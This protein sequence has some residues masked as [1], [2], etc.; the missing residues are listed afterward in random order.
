MNATR[1][2]LPL[3][4][5]LAYPV[6]QAQ[7]LNST[8]DLRLSDATT[9][10]DP[11]AP[12]GDR[13]SAAARLG[14]TGDA[15]VLPFLRAG[16][17]DPLGA[18][19]TA[20]VTALAGVVDPA[21]ARLAA[22]V[23]ADPSRDDDARAAAVATLAALR[24]P[25]AGEILYDAASDRSLP[26]DLRSLAGA[27]VAQSYPELVAARGAPHRVSSLPGAAAGV[28]G[29]GLAGG[30]L[31]SSVG[32]W[33]QSDAGTVIGG[34]GGG[35]IGVGSGA[36]YAVTRPVTAGQGTAY[37]SAVGW[38]LTAGVMG[39]RAIYG[40]RGGS[41]WESDLRTQRENVGAGLRALGV[42]AGT[43]TGAL[44][45]RRDPSAEDVL[46]ADLAGYL[47]A[48]VGLA[49]VDL[50]S[51]GA[52]Y[53]CLYRGDGSIDCAA[54]SRWRQGRNAA[55]L[56]GLGAGLGLGAA[57]RQGWDPDLADL[58]FSAAVATETAVVARLLPD[59]LRAREPKGTVRLALHGGAALAQVAA[60]RWEV[61][62]GHT[63]SMVWGGALGTALGAGIPMLM[64]VDDFAPVAGGMILG[65]VAGTAG[66]LLA[67]PALDLSGG[68]LAMLGVGVSFMAAESAAIGYVLEEKGDR[69]R[70]DLDTGLALTATSITGVGLTALTRAV[71]PDAADMYFL[72]S[73]GA[74]GVWY[75]VL[76]PIA[77]RAEGD[78]ADLVLTATV[79]GDVFLGLGGLALSPVVGL[80]PRRTVVAQLGGAGGATVGALAA[81][82][83][84]GDPANVA[85]GAVIGSTVGLAGGALATRVWSPRELVLRRPHLDLPGRWTASLAPTADGGV[86]GQVLVTGW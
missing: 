44:L 78:R 4:V 85:Q 64:D 37:A 83:G 66:G 24:L 5:L 51:G 79:T 71:A 36:L 30:V 13:T 63:A 29:N 49:T 6:A 53:G 10:L 21:A 82:L 61:P 84:S 42:A 31:L 23:L 11:A 77:L 1:A 8:A 56:V 60:D 80:D 39:T 16:T 74:W 52:A 32:T 55:G 65:G 50:A 57:F 9:L 41:Y 75:G 43:T 22:E 68:D 58:S 19:Q 15:A 59:A 45:L 81:A 20:A 3:S 34:V 62:L 25:E 7:E 69:V 28:A 14:Q 70:P 46:S 18:V 72:G 67:G 54:A 38:G 17:L 73:A 86:V 33:G 76:T 2:W 12:L 47:G 26:S 35:V 40:E 27:A 48:Q